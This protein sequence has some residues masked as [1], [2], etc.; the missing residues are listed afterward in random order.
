MSEDL[1]ELLE[2]AKDASKK[3]YAPYS[4]FHVGAAVRLLN[5]NIVPGNNQENGSYPIGTCAERVALN[6]ARGQDPNVIVIAIAVYAF[7]KKFKVEKP[8][9]P[10]GMCRQAILEVEKDQ[11]E[12]IIVVLSGP[13][14]E[15]YLSNSISDL[16]PFAFVPT[17]LK[18]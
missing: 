12:N 11:D 13:S 1:H 7:S 18:K 15:V 4:E 8:V 17:L 5:G 2:V 3:A 16:L 6:F 9:S 14:D 10:C